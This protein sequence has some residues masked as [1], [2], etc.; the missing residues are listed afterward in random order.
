MRI[1]SLLPSSTE[2]VYALGLGGDLSAVTHECDFPSEASEKPQ[3][4]SS[5]LSGG[6]TPADIDG[7]VR[8]R[9]RSGEGLYR[10]DEDLLRRIEPDLILTQRLCEVC[11]VNYDDVLAVARSLP[12]PPEI[13]SLE[14]TTIDDILQTVLD[15][16]V[17]TGRE[18][19]A[20]RLV[21]GLRARIDAVRK[22]VSGAPRTPRTL[23][24]EWMDPPMV[25]GHWVPEMVRAAGGED[26]LG[27]AGSPSRRIGWDEIEGCAPDVVVLMPCG[28]D[29]GRTEEEFRRAA[30][31]DA[32]RRLPAV[33]GSRVFGVDANAF[34]SR[35]GP[36]F[37]EGIEI[38][39][40]ML[41]PEMF[42]QH[43]AAGSR[44]LA[45]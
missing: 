43:H 9:L 30:F 8:R 6:G 11:A 37:V 42:E 5:I 4:T 39:G 23:C 38:L 17:K 24:L 16:G 41:H 18:E 31:P 32:W 15:V 12:R 45:P 26:V 20:S 36:R 35:P 21:K 33:K 1:C 40:R 14:P 3:I 44:R 13:L 19:E 29:L 2:I 27:K 7:E 25:G 22:A 34:F 10:I 28:Y